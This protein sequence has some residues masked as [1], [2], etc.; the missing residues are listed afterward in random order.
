VCLHY[1]YDLWTVQ[2]R[3]RQAKGQ[4]ITVRYADDVVVGFELEADARAFWD[5]MRDSIP[6]QGK[7]LRAVG[8]L[9]RPGYFS[10]H[11]VPTNFRALAAFR[12][13]VTD[14]WRRSQKDK[15]TLKRMD[16]IANSWLPRTRI[17]HPWP[18]DR[19]AVKHPRW[20]PSA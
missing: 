16:D 19:F 7:W 11:V 3:Q 13:N 4:M 12:R 9:S 17:L 10:T 8:L 6:E 15:M 20:E 2:W 5:A 1:V 18:S 14:L